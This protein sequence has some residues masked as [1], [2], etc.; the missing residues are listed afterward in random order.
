MYIRNILLNINKITKHK[1]DKNIMKYFI[2]IRWYLKTNKF[3]KQLQTR[4][5]KNLTMSNRT[6]GKRL[7]HAKHIQKLH[8]MKIGREAGDTESSKST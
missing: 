4:W 2:S 6:S 7:K 5:G 3:N 1:H 8:K